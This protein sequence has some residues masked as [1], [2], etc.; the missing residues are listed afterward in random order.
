MT[1]QIYFT[2]PLKEPLPMKNISLASLLV[3]ILVTMNGCTSWKY[4]KKAPPKDNWETSRD[5]HT[6]DDSEIWG[7]II[8]DQSTGFFVIAVSYG[9]AF[10][11]IEP[12]VGLL[13]GAIF[14]LPGIYYYFAGNE[15]IADAQHCSDYKSF[16]YNRLQ[17]N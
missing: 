8:R 14:A 9:I 3:F 2:P 17:D 5:F 16:M 7:N 12:A 4:A 1:S 13:T 6:C 15:S 11:S 10:A